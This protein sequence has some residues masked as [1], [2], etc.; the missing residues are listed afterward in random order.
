VSQVRKVQLALTGEEYE[1]LRSLAEKRD[2]SVHELIRQAIRQAYMND[3]EQDL[4]VLEVQRVSETSLLV[5]EEEEAIG[6]R[7]R[8]L[9]AEDDSLA[10]D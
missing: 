5:D 8:G 3:L 2:T 6:I 1:R 4:T 7:G 9:L 10:A